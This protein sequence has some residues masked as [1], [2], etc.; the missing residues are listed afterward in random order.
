MTYLT[1]P[2]AESG[3]KKKYAVLHDNIHRALTSGQ[4]TLALKRQII[5]E[6]IHRAL[7]LDSA[8]ATPYTLEQLEHVE[9]HLDE[10]MNE[11][12]Q[13]A[14]YT[15]G[16]PYSDEQLQQTARAMNGD[17]AAWPRI[18]QLLTA[19]T[20]AELDNMVRALSGGTVAPAP[21][22]D[23]VM[24]DN[25][26][27]TGRNM[28]SIN[29]E[30]TPDPQ[31]WEDGRRLAEATLAKYR[32]QHGDYPRKVSYTLWA[33]E[34][35]ASGGATIAQVL[36]M[37]GVEP[38]RDSQGRILSLRLVPSCELKRPR[39]DVV[40]QVSGQ[41]RD[42]ADSRLKLITEAIRLAATAEAGDCDYRNY[43]SEGVQA[44][45]Q[46]LLAKGVVPERAREL[47]TL[48]VFGP[49]NGGYSTGMMDLVEQGDKWSGREEI[50]RQY[51]NNMGAAYGD[52]QHWGAF[53]PH[54]FASALGQT[55][56]V[57]QPRQSNTWGP[58]SLDHVYEFTGG[59]SLVVKSLT[60]KEPEALLADYRNPRCRRMQNLREAI[61]IEARTTLLNPTYIRE[62]MKGD[63]GTAHM[64]GE[65]FRNIF[66]WST[67]RPSA[68]DSQL[69]DQL[70]QLYVED[71]EH[72]GIREFFQQKN[73][74]AYQSMT[75]VLLEGARKGYWQPDAN[76][77]QRLV[78][79]RDHLVRQQEGG[80]PLPTSADSLSLR[81]DSSSPAEEPSPISPWTVAAIVAVA[82]LLLGLVI[83]FFR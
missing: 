25:V 59:I 9:A 78:S 26:L 33:G 56:V 57:V 55:D 52:E 3:L 63:E 76:Q 10:L 69:Y 71:T 70:Y 19:S 24:N 49:L 27:P 81:T 38:D 46:Q 8:L 18:R 73:P 74:A 2:Y 79:M 30:N 45:E 50:V 41:L 4:T 83:R 7:G 43:V 12:M 40:V 61:D 28:F 15:L 29:P 5:G 44:Q 65:M 60:G 36:W 48:R 68:L 77:A 35:I 58:L 75:D 62:R 80:R 42:I 23:P 17:P 14:Y 31:A 13:G 66:G 6:G 47:S 54:L 1:P 53:E 32:Q 22:G 16:Q 39:I 82:V 21:G 34:F 72:L 64:F 11:K 20:Q 37:L 67:T 51:L